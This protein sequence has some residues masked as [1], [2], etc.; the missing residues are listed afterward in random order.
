MIIFLL[1]G[2]GP[3]ELHSSSWCLFNFNVVNVVKIIFVVN[4]AKLNGL[5]IRKYVN[6]F[7]PYWFIVHF[8]KLNLRLQRG[9]LYVT[10]WLAETNYIFMSTCRIM[11]AVATVYLL[12]LHARH[13]ISKILT[14][15]CFSLAK[16]SV[17][18]A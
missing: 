5:S 9:N 12:Y 11:I 15:I 3:Q 1:L 8:R 13:I 18:F 2:V 10:T 16:R 7:S 6:Y 14:N 4:T 17:Y